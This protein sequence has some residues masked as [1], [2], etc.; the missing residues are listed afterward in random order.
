[1]SKLYAGVSRVD[2]STGKIKANDPLYAKILVLKNEK[3]IYAIIS[4]DYVSMGGGISELSDDFFPSLKEKISALGIDCILC[5]VTHTH[6]HFPM[7]DEE[8]TVKEKIIC[9]VK[10]TLKNLQPVSV[11]SGTGKN[12]TFLINRTLKLDD[13]SYWSVRQ[14]HPC[15]PDDR[16]ESVPFSDDE[17]GIIRFDKEDNVPLCVLFTF[18]CHPLVGYSNNLATANFPGIAEKYIEENTGA[19]A[20]MFQSC[21]GDVTEIDYKNY[22]KPKNCYNWGISLGQSVVEAFKNI[23]TKTADIKFV[24]KNISLPLRKDFK[25][26]K[27]T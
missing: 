17:I 26:V 15:P 12:N 19:M 2:I 14:A 10:E 25:K 20:M 27:E 23:K 1:M 24:E 21:G 6:T 11:G 13:G 4:L 5:G 8:K 3:N 22:D 9:A 7:C 18:G 16:I